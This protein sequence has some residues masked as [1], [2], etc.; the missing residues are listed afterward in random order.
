MLYTVKNDDTLPVIAKKFAVTEHAL[1]Q[2]NAICNPE[3]LEA[4]R[5]LSIPVAGQTAG[6]CGGTPYY[7]TQPGDSIESVSRCFNIT[8]ELLIKANN[9]KNGRLFPYSELLIVQWIPKPGE[10]K[11]IWENTG[12]RYDGALAPIDIHDI[13]YSGTFMWEA[14]RK[15]ALVPLQQLI[16]H[17]CDMV[18]LFTA[19]SLARLAIKGGDRMVNTLKQARGDRNPFVGLMASYAL[20]RINLAFRGFRRIHIL[21]VDSMLFEKPDHYSPATRLSR[22]THV[23][24]LQ[25]HIPGTSV[26]DRVQVVQS[27]KTGFL[28]RFLYDET[29]LV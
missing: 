26:F 8:P 7:I 1:L 14:M 4:G 20:E 29:P 5:V 15:D 28:Q 23:A 9:I 12:D 27:G 6:L 24:V 17:K 22:G 3:Y 10:L 25:W 2:A 21:S 18:R 13:Y 19:D 16:R 11:K